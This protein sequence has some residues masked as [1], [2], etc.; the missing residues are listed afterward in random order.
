MNKKFLML[1]LI[2]FLLL[3]GCKSNEKKEN[4]DRTEVMINDFE[5]IQQL[6]LMK[7]PFPKHS[8]RGRMDLSDQH[9][10]HGQKS[11]KYSNEYGTSLEVCHYF[12][13]ISG[14]E[15]AVSDIRSLEVDI[16]NDSPFDAS[17]VL[18][19][20]YEKN[21]NVLLSQTYE[22]KKGTSTHLSFPL[23]KIALEYNAASINS[24]SLRLNM[25]ETDYDRGVG[26]T[27]YL[28]NWHAKMGAVF[29]EDDNRYSPV[30]ESVKKKIDALPP[31]RQISKSDEAA[32]KEISDLIAGLPDLYRPI[33]SNLEAFRA[34]VKT[35]DRVNAA[36]QEIDYDYYPFLELDKFYGIAQLVPDN[37]TKGDAIY[38]E[39]IWSGNPN[40][41]STKISFGGS[42]YNRLS[43][44]SHVNLL[45]FDTIEITVHNASQN[46]TKVWVS[47]A[48]GLAID[49]DAGQTVTQSFP[50]KSL[51]SQSYWEVVQRSWRYGADIPASGAIY[52]AP[53]YVTGRSE[54]TLQRHL[55]HAIECLPDP[56]TVIEEDD[57]LMALTAMDTASYLYGE[58]EDQSTVSPEA[59]AKLRALEAKA[60]DAGYGIRY[61]AYDKPMKR[62]ETYGSDL[63]SKAGVFDD[64]FGFVSSGNISVNPVHKDDPNLHEQA[65]SFVANV[66]LEEGDLG[67]V[68]YIYNPTPYSLN[69]EVRT[70]D[71]D[72]ETYGPLFTRMQLERGWNKVEMKAGLFLPDVPTSDHKVAFFVSDGSQ[73]RDM[74]GEWKFS[75][76][77]SVPRSI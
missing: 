54:E 44:Y 60:A 45:D 56:D 59:L 16:Y 18:T 12:D 13:H 47:Y 15:I 76:L 35:F 31:E 50:T 36:G 63:T 75:S 58:V 11:L 69:L 65:F 41:G 6:S 19:V 28:D 20:Y 67:Y 71:W 55:Q 9:A 42:T 3:G 27:F 26:Y 17:A 21:M 68:M 52:F 38:S 39:D 40:R 57:Y 48:E 66:A 1:S 64:A 62:W 61:N 77:F 30:I 2:P 72:W 23:S 5:S 10:T 22:L 8:D 53:S 74:T 32:L 73:N 14:G 25:P 34:A 24:T 37:S 51:T 46:F 70:T 7:F 43:Y 33:V 4:E 29:T 49:I